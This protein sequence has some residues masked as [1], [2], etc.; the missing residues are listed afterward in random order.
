M[1]YGDADHTEKL[2]GY[3]NMYIYNSGYEHDTGRHFY[4]Y[5]K[6][7]NQR[8]RA[9]R[10]L[11]RSKWRKYVH[12]IDENLGEK[13]RVLGIS[14]LT[15]D[16]LPFFRVFRIPGLSFSL[17]TVDRHPII[18]FSDIINEY[19]SHSDY[20]NALQRIDDNPEDSEAVEMVELY[21]SHNGDFTQ[22]VIDALS[23]TQ[24]TMRDLTNICR[25]GVYRN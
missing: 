18:G 16:I 8:V 14:I 22:L 3:V 6:N 9:Q 13:A 1:W 24:L 7:V 12:L 11:S 19:V 21:E 4:L 10:I 15:A 2:H 23:H 17:L 20:E 5:F 25:T